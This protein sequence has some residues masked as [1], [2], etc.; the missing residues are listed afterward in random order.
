MVYITV[1]LVYV[2]SQEVLYI[3]L[4]SD[5]QPYH[6]DFS[7]YLPKFFL[8]WSFQNIIISVQYIN[9]FYLVEHALI[10]LALPKPVC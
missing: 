9:A 3:P 1:H 7:Y 8:I 5:I 10:N 4:F 2:E 6:L